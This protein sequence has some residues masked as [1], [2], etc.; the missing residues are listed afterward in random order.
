MRAEETDAAVSP[1]VDHTGLEK[2]IDQGLSVLKAAGDSKWNL[3]RDRVLT[4]AGDERVVGLRNRSKPLPPLRIISNG[5]T[6][7]DRL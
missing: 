6:A 2:L 3:I 4:P 1:N 7:S 5:H